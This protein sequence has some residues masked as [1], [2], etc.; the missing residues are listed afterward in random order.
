MSCFLL[1][2]RELVAFTHRYYAVVGA[3]ADLSHLISFLQESSRA[4]AIKCLSKKH[5]IHQACGNMCSENLLLTALY[6][7]F[8]EE[9]SVF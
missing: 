6:I 4:L 1:S 5:L 3:S 7:D 8:F 9:I 2:F